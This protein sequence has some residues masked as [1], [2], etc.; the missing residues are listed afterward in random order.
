MPKVKASQRRRKRDVER[1][2][3]SSLEEAENVV[4]MATSDLEDNV[5]QL[6][7]D[8]GFRPL[9]ISSGSLGIEIKYLT[10]ERPVSAVVG[11]GDAYI[12]RWEEVERSANIIRTTTDG[13]LHAFKQGEPEDMDLDVLAEV[14]REQLAEQGQDNDLEE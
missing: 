5:K 8:I 9:S 4:G 1:D 10:K 7:R 14:I 13:Q 3:E 11:I 12:I 6:I 2:L